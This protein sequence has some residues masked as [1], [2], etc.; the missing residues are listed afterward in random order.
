M[1]G[2]RGQLFFPLCVVVA[3][4][5]A[6]A[7]GQWLGGEKPRDGMLRLAPAAFADLPGWDA[8]DFTDAGI[9]LGR[10]CSRLDDLPEDRELGGAGYAGTVAD[11]RGFCAAVAAIDAADG[12]ALR[13]LL[14]QWLT[15][16]RVIDGAQETG[17]FTGYYEASLS[18]SRRRHGTFQIPIL[19]LPPDL[20]SVDLGAF[21]AEFRGRRI[22]GRIADGRLLPYADRAAIET[23][24][25]ADQGLEIAWVDDPVDAFFLHI[26]GSGRIALDDG[27]DMRVGYAAQNGHAYRAIGRDLVDS[28][29]IARPDIS[30]QSIRHWMAAHPDAAR[31]LMRRNASYVFFRELTGGGPI[32]AGGSVLTPARSLAV[33]R[34]WHALDVPAWF[35][36][37]VPDD[38]GDAASPARQMARLMVT[39]DTGGAITGII[40]G[41]VFWGHGPRAAS[42]AG[43]MQGQGRLWLLLP[44][45]LA[46]KRP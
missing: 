33:D 38:T 7:L 19:G 40:R 9:A 30:M 39:Q 18:G 25:L 23:G 34:K 35:A 24:A 42:I 22:A 44:K 32:G 26:Q 41:D 46:A 10:S 36:G 15:P 20:I 43:R 45:P 29:A 27:S 2:R 12:N 14:Q 1:P 8:D 13:P 11:W 6:W 5:I 3:V 16:L 37:Q 28:G 21:R 4:A 31:T 17:L